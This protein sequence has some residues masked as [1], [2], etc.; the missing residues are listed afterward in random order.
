MS[1]PGS[2]G[3]RR[4]EQPG[5]PRTV[6]LLL[7]LPPRSVLHRGLFPSPS[8]CA[9]CSPVLPTVSPTFSLPPVFKSSSD[10]GRAPPPLYT[11][12]MSGEETAKQWEA[13]RPLACKP[14]GTDFSF[15]QGII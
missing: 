14:Q 2:L 1:G 12:R 4:Q 10:D 6:S 9:Q 15:H 8:G 13:P 3:H 7:N 5:T 11:G